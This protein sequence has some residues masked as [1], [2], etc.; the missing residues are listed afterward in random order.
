MRGILE[1]SNRSTI[2]SAD[3]LYK[4]NVLSRFVKRYLQI[5]NAQLVGQFDKTLIL[6]SEC[7]VPADEETARTWALKEFQAGILT[8]NEYNQKIGHDTIA[9]GDYY[10]RPNGLTMVPAAEAMVKPVTP[11]PPITPAPAPIKAG[12]KSF[13]EDVKTK[14]WNDFDTKAK[15]AERS[16]IETVKKMSG[17]QEAKFKKSFFGALDRNIEVEKAFE[18]AIISTFNGKMDVETFNLMAP[19]WVKALKEGG[20]LAQGLLKTTINFDLMNPVFSSWVKDHGLEQAKEINGTTREYLA[21]LKEPIAESVRKG[22]S[23][24]KISAML[25]KEF[26]KLSSTR[27]DL[28]ARTETMSSVNFGQF[29][30]YDS[31]GV[32]EIEWLSSTDKSVRDSH[33]ISGEKVKIGKKFSNGLLFPGDSQN[34]AAKDVC[35]CRCTILPVVKLEE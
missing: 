20:T 16:F 3:Y 27:A 26:D 4:K 1:N 12:K 13:S 30:V 28:I 11:A 6:V 24:D 31:D 10:L 18:S 23:I 2:D 7:V 17:I 14:H 19:D 34:G 15:N 35:N 25:Q 32:E 5:L 33:K 8:L 21:K 9:N 22:E 29:A